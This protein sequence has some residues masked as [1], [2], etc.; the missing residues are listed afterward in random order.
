MDLVEFLQQ[1][2]EEFA[3]ENDRGLQQMQEQ[4]QQQREQSD[5]R[6]Q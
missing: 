4:E 3:E 2:N 6:T 1:L 5:E